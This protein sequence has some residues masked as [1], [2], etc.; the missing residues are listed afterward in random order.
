MV[1]LGGV[2]GAIKIGL[3]TYLITQYQVLFRLQIAGKYLIVFKLRCAGQ[4][5]ILLLFTALVSAR[6]LHCYWRLIRADL[7]LNYLKYKFTSSIIMHTIVDIW[8]AF[9][10]SVKHLVFSV[11]I[12]LIGN[13]FEL[14]NSA[15]NC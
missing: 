11:K 1:S 6:I 3:L 13:Y 5:F 4:Y 14:S 7:A 10:D 12:A 2:N 8:N 9:S 15:K